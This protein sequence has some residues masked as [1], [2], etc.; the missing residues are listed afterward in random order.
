MELCL[1]GDAF[2]DE[3]DDFI[4][5]W[6]DNENIPKEISL[7]DYLGMTWDEYSLWV[8]DSD[9]LSSIISARRKRID[10]QEEL[11]EELQPLAARASSTEEAQ[12]ILSWL[13]EQGEI[14]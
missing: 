8:N 6:H 11:R 3:I 4:D 14:E 13:K 2:L 12:K 10:L 7:H 9:I 5:T 1:I